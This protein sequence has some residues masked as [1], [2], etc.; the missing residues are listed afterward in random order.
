MR[1]VPTAICMHDGHWK[2]SHLQ[3]CKRGCRHS[4][5]PTLANVR[6]MGKRQS[7]K[8]KFY[9]RNEKIHYLCKRGYKSGLFCKF[10]DAVFRTSWQSDLILIFSANRK[11]S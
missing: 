11:Q 2:M 5:V 4:A 7:G 9:R 1:K 10:L 3:R 6:E 8:N